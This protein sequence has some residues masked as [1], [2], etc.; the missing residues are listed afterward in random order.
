MNAAERLE[1]ELL[2]WLGLLPDSQAPNTEPNYE[3]RLRRLG[4]HL[5]RKN[6]EPQEALA[7]LALH[8]LA[9]SQEG[10]KLRSYHL[11]RARQLFLGARSLT[12]L[13]GEADAMGTELE[14]TAAQEVA[15]G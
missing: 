12:A 2:E 4:E 15:H 7:A 8:Y 14:A 11:G 9:L 13:E 1:L 6:V 10:G 5:H 3:E